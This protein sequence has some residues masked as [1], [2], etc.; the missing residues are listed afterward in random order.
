MFNYTDHLGNIRL[1]YGIDPGT[2]VL[3]IIEENHYYPFGLKH[4]NYNSDLLLYQKNEEGGIELKGPTTPTTPFYQYK[5]LGQEWQ[6]ELGLDWYSMKW[7]NADPAI[8]RFMGIDPISEDYMSISTYQFAHNNPVWK[9]EIEGLE[10]QTSNETGDVINDEPTAVEKGL[11]WGSEFLMSA[12]GTLFGSPTLST[13]APREKIEEQ[14][15]E[16]NVKAQIDGAIQSGKEFLKDPVKSIEKAYEGTKQVVSDLFSGEADK[17]G[18]AAVLVAPIIVTL[19]TPVP[20]DELVATESVVS[21]TV[22][23]HTRHGLNQSISRNGGRGVNASAKLDAIKNPKKVTVQ[24]NGNTAYKGKNATV[25]TNS[26]GKIVT[27]FGKSRS[28]SSVPQGRATGGG[29]AQRRTQ[30]TT[31]SSYNPNSIR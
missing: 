26:E 17:T 22:T 31:G 3:K 18:N 30:K 14:T 19:F 11:T 27:T 7:R 5:Y 23:G 29:K 9:I 4:T 21:R 8:G 16:V 24:S 20:G 13:V 25:V 12:A 15:N 10:G 28:S 6:D 1:S 2:G